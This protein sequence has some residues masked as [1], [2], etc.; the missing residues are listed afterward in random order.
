MARV[1]S[2][3]TLTAASGAQSAEGGIKEVNFVQDSTCN[4]MNEHSA[5][6]LKV[7]NLCKL[8]KMCGRESKKY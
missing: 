5:A 4:R 8:D 2:D 3:V 1:R 7:P 6:D